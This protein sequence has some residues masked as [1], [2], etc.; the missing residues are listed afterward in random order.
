VRKALAAVGATSS[1]RGAC[2]LRGD[3]VV[4]PGVGTSTR[5]ARSTTP[6]A[7]RSC[8]RRSR[9][10]AARHLP[11]LQYLFE[12]SDEAPERPGSGCCAGRCTLLPPT[13]KVPHV[14]WNALHERASIALL[15]GIRTAT[16]V[17]F[18]HS[19]AAPITEDA[20][21]RR[22]RRTFASAVERGR[23]FG[24]QFHP[25]KSG[26][27]GLASS[28]LREIP[29]SQSQ[30]PMHAAKRLIACLDVRDGCVVKG[31]QF[32]D[33]RRRRSG[34]AGA[35]LQR[36]GIDELVILDVTATIETAARWPTRARG[37]AELFIP[38][39]RRRRHPLRGRRR[40]GARRRRR[41]GA[42]NSA[43]LANPRS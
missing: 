42:L 20:W 14:G 43:A 6:G 33:S 8:A 37:A 28:V 31:V 16:Q 18:T 38:L 23:V 11:R 24:V 27:A 39:D 41:Q 21:R 13:V 34:G 26:D 3:G 4:I 22:A 15:D 1:R 5:R 17:Y 30:I 19:Y 36:G 9:R 7:R 35:P 40:G 2:D 10:A 29:I 12:G 32:E 25:E